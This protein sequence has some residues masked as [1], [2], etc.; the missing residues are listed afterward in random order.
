M[1]TRMLLS[2]MVLLGTTAAAGAQGHHRARVALTLAPVVAAPS[3]RGAKL[4]S[5]TGAGPVVAKLA[6][7]ETFIQDHSALVEHDLMLFPPT[8]IGI[9]PAPGRRG[10]ELFARP[11]AKREAHYFTP[12]KVADDLEV[13]RE[14]DRLLLF[15]TPHP[16][17]ASI[18]VGLAMFGAVTILAAH[19]PGAL[20]AI[21]DG[22]VHLGP[23]VFDGG[24]MGAGIAGR[25]L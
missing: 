15:N 17:G 4:D 5:E 21:F 10:P 14:R 22:P 16:Q 11:P 9:T 3:N 12:I 2:L 1:A 6:K 24:G 19:A 20:R 23:A 7:P 8:L 25:G 13:R 18:G